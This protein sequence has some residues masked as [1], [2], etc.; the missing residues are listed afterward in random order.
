MAQKITFTLAL[1]ALV[2]LT[3]FYFYPRELMFDYYADAAATPLSADEIKTLKSIHI[4]C[5]A[6]TYR[7]YLSTYYKE[8][9]ELHQPGQLA[10]LDSK[11]TEVMASY[12]EYIDRKYKDIKNLYI[13]KLAGEVI[14]EFTCM[15]DNDFTDGNPIL[16]DVCLD[17]TKRGH[18]YGSQM[19]EYAIEHCSKPGKPLVLTVYKDQSGLVK[20]YEKLGFE[21]VNFEHAPDESFKYYNKYLMRYKGKP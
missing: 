11:M 19:T 9:Y 10:A 18:G 1:L 14:G 21:V 7:K 13:V 2:L 17:S 6:D 15:T 4:E 3:V 12:R 5:F 20:L 8:R 16:Y